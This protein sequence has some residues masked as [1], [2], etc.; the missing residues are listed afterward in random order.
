MFVCCCVCAQCLSSTFLRERFVFTMS[1]KRARP[2]TTS[3]EPP[4]Y[5][6]ATPF[7]NTIAVAGPGPGI[8][9]RDGFDFHLVEDGE[10][11]EVLKMSETGP[12]WGASSDIPTPV[13]I[14]LGGT[15]ATS[16]L[17]TALV[18]GG[19]PYTFFNMY[20]QGDYPQTG[21]NVKQPIGSWEKAFL[22]PAGLVTQ[23]VGSFRIDPLFVVMGRGQI[24]VTSDPDVVTV[25]SCG[26]VTLPVGLP[27]IPFMVYTSSI[28]LESANASVTPA[29][30]LTRNNDKITIT[31]P[32]AQATIGDWVQYTLH[33]THP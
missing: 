15:G 31:A 33:I 28:T 22:L 12:Q 8:M 32:T 16:S 4:V 23:N 27:R 13:P 19:N 21:S 5:L 1:G 29:W 30:S 25:Q 10:P 24:T 7:P 14:S 2:A 3:I 11:G 20:Q 26:S 18:R 17:G 6:T 9:R